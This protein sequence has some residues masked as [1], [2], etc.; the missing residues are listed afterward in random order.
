MLIHNGFSSLILLVLPYFASFYLILIIFEHSVYLYTHLESQRREKSEYRTRTAAK[1]KREPALNPNWNWNWPKIGRE[2]IILGGTCIKR[3]WIIQ[4][5]S[6]WNRRKKVFLNTFDWKLFEQQ[7]KWVKMN[8]LFRWAK[9]HFLQVLSAVIDV[10]LDWWW[11][12][13]ATVGHWFLLCFKIIGKVF[14]G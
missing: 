2:Q 1:E 11:E 12:G 9:K 13:W 8:K 14:L 5:L 10:S 3:P 4:N 7:S 6:F